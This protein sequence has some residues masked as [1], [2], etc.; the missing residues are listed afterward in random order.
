M[1]SSKIESAL[2]FTGVKVMP[3]ASLPRT[4]SVAREIDRLKSEG[5]HFH[6][7]ALAYITNSGVAYGCHFGMK[8]TRR[9]AMAEFEAGYKLARDDARAY[10]AAPWDV[11]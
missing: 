5:R 6:A 9:A 2:P 7:G 3:R 8:S 10:G 1:T 4:V 11:A